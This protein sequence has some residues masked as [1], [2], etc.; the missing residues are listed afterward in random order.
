M[1]VLPQEFQMQVTDSLRALVVVAHPGSDSLSHGLVGRVSA[2]LQRQGFKVEVADL[3]REQF[4][5]TM[6]QADMDLFRGV[7]EIPDDVAREQAR[8]D[9]ADLLVFIF[10]V[11]WWSLPGQLKGWFDRVF[12]A[13]WAWGAN[14]RMRRVPI[15]LIATAGGDQELFDRR[16]YTQAIQTQIVDGIFGYVEQR[17]VELA[18]F[19]E[20]ES[21]TEADVDTFWSRVR[22]MLAL[23]T[24]AD[25]TLFASASRDI[26]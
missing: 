26:S 19:Y 21:A 14:A 3:G 5:A 12:S 9:R 17:E 23:K 15:R 4:Q 1:T 13:G 11:F 24:A 20:A 6:T 7:G 25:A 16:G 8:V 18:M 10:P 2:E 22:P